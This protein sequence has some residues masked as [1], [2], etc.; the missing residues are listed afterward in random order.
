[1]FEEKGTHFESLIFADL[2]QSSVA[3]VGLYYYKASQPF[4]GKGTKNVYFLNK[5]I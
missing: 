4:S 2:D 1:M 3:L 5:D